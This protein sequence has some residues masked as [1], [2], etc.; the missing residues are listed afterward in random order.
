MHIELNTSCCPKA[1]FRFIGHS[2]YVITYHMYPLKPKV[3]NSFGTDTT[4]RKTAICFV[5]ISIEFDRFLS[6][7]IAAEKA[8]RRNGTEL[9]SLQIVQQPCTTYTQL[10]HNIYYGNEVCNI[11]FIVQG[12]GV[13]VE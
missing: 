9:C 5:L 7:S 2:N 8:Q 1:I 13:H 10:M 12:K 4:E 6:G 3:E 11:F